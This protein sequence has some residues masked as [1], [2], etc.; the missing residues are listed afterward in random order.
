MST[1][2]MMVVY[3]INALSF[4]IMKKLITK[5]GNRL[6]NAIQKEIEKINNAPRRTLKDLNRLKELRYLLSDHEKSE[7][8]FVIKFYEQ[9]LN[10]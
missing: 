8:D 3:A 1:Y 10:E 6:S 2:A 4:Y 5:K 9:D 7:I